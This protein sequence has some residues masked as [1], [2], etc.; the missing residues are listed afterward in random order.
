MCINFIGGPNDL[1]KKI[2]RMYLGKFKAFQEKFKIEM[3]EGRGG[4]YNGVTIRYILK[5]EA[6]LQGLKD[7]FADKIAVGEAVYEYL[8]ATWQV[9]LMCMKP[10][11][12]EN[13]NTIIKQFRKKFRVVSKLLDVPWTIKIH[14]ILGEY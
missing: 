11:I 13:Y 2:K 3:T 4:V 5:T 9:Y 7:L 14:V 8:K 10:D 1:F 12:D 6:V